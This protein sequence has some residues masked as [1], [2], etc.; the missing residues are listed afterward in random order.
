MCVCARVTVCVC[1]T[2]QKP[3][4]KDTLKQLNTTTQFLNY[5]LK[6]ETVLSK[7]KWKNGANTFISGTE[8]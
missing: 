6:A 3:S 5:T 2:Y 7:V 1:Q 4:E 8:N